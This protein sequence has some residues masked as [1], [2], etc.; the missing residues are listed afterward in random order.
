[1]HQLVNKNFDSIKM[2]GTMGRNLVPMYQR[3]LLPPFRVNEVCV[4]HICIMYSNESV[5]L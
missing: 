1:V 2:Q 3:N 5:L 4:Q